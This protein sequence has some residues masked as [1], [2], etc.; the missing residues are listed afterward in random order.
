[1]GYEVV[2]NLCEDFS[3][4]AR[5]SIFLTDKIFDLD[6]LIMF[7]AIYLEKQQIQLQGDLPEELVHDTLKVYDLFFTSL[8]RDFIQ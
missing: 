7:F 3:I 4:F 6:Y 2:S 8:K 1:M 5:E